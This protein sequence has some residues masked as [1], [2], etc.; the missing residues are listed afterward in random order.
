M[1]TKRPQRAHLGTGDGSSWGLMP[2]HRQ[3]G[4]V[5]GEVSLCT[6]RT[7]ARGCLA[8]GKVGDSN[9]VVKALTLNPQP[10]SSARG[11]GKSPKHRGSP[12]GDRALLQATQ[13]SR[14]IAIDSKPTALLGDGAPAAT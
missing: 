4:G 6:P 1:K 14:L 12:V 10:S 5:D 9:P 7:G 8:K 2:T 11:H 13:T 3:R